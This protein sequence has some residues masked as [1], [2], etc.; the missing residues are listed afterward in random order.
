MPLSDARF[1][2]LIESTHKAA[3][4]NVDIHQERLEQRLRELSPALLVAYQDKLCRKIQALAANT[5]SLRAAVTD[6]GADD[7]FDDLCHWIVS[8]GKDAYQRALADPKTVRS[9]WERAIKKA[10]VPTLFGNAYIIYHE[11]TGKSMPSSAPPRPIIKPRRR[12]ANVPQTARPLKVHWQAEFVPDRDKRGIYCI[13]LSKQLQ[14]VA[15]GGANGRVRLW[16]TRGKFV[17]DLQVVPNDEDDDE[18]E[19]QGVREIVIDDSGRLATKSRDSNAFYLT[20]FDLK[21]GRRKGQLQGHWSQALCSGISADGSLALTNDSNYGP[22]EMRSLGNLKLMRTFGKRREV[23]DVATNPDF[24]RIVTRTKKDFRVWD[25]RT[26]EKLRSIGLHAKAQLL[27]VS[28][29]GRYLLADDGHQNPALIWDLETGEK[30]QNPGGLVRQKYSA[31]SQ[32][33]ASYDH[34]KEIITVW[35]LHSTEKLLTIPFRGPNT[36]FTFAP[37]HSLIAVS[38]NG[39]VSQWDIRAKKMLSHIK[40][41]NQSKN[42]FDGISSP[43]GKTIFVSNEQSVYCLK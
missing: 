7:E 36:A 2:E 12:K 41:P 28:P 4:G 42:D 30:L 35:D 32:F 13:A 24:S 43:D 14:L 39:D 21:S 38:A 15:A 31:N 16:N 9:R 6:L 17:R 40:I 29:D 22:L 26:G 34:A 23:F 10:P 11:L 1:W 27:D 5:E 3:R 25:G 8:F 33:A 18:D 37:D 20:T 19:Y